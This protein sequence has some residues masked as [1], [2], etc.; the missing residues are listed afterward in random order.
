MTR[1]EQILNA[2]L[3]QFADKSYEGASLSAIASKVGIKKASIYNHFSHKEEL[4]LSVAKY[5]YNQYIIEIERV[6]SHRSNRH[7]EELILE[8]I[9][10]MT[11]FLSDKKAGKFYMHFLLF[12]PIPLKEKVYDH[13]LNFEDECDRLL[14]PIFEDI[15]ETFHIDTMSLRDLLDAFYCLLD[16]ITTQ[17]FYYDEKT[18]NRKR[19]AAWNLFW[20]GIKNYAKK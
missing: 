3:E 18:R 10:T 8:V 2:A 17:M 13:F 14:S 19:L 11:N 4:F 9:E 5:V 15:I 12:P 16:G 7:A 1:S 6:L 20:S